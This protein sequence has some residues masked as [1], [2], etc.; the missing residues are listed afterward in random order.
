LAPDSTEANEKG[1]CQDEHGRGQSYPAEGFTEEQHPDQHPHQDAHL[2]YRHGVAHG[3]QFEAVAEGEEGCHHDRPTEEDEP[4]VFPPFGADLAPVAGA[5]QV[6][7]HED[8]HDDHHQPGKVERR[9]TL[10]A[11]LVQHG[12]EGVDKA[13]GQGGPHR[14]VLQIAERTEQ[15]GKAEALHLYRVGAKDNQGD[16]AGADEGQLFTHEQ[17]APYGDVDHGSLAERVG[18]GEI[19]GAIGPAG[20]QVVEDKTAAAGDADQDYLPVGDGDRS[21]NKGE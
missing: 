2:T 18:E 16:A 9:V 3:G 11:G 5:E 12:A 20:E 6:G 17:A 7:A 4:P 21:G 15:F 8:Q 19:A 1:A 14:A 10:H 13:G